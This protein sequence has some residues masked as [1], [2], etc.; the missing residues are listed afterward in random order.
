MSLMLRA[1]AAERDALNVEVEYLR[2]WHKAAF[3]V[4]PNIDLDMESDP[5]ARAALQAQ[6]A[7]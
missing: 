5:D 2:R 1:L 7:P 6:E 4:H 3:L